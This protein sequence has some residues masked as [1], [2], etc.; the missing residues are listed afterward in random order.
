MNRSIFIVIVDFLLLSLLAFARFDSDQ[1]V[2]VRKGGQL[3]PQSS[4]HEKEMVNVLK[5]SL[6]EERQARD[7]LAAELNQAQSTLRSREELLAER[8][9]RIQESQLALKRKSDEAAK[10]AAE[11]SNLENQFARA[12]TN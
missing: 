2:T 9:R 5:L 11:R 8:E 1:D 6:E 10:L 12:Q 3:A 4:A 7:Q